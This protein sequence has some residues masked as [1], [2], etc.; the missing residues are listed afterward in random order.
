MSDSPIEHVVVLMME[1]HSY[2]HM[3]GY[4]P[5]PI[6]TLASTSQ[7][8]PNPDTSNPNPPLYCTTE[9]N[10]KWSIDP[11]PRH[12]HPDVMQQIYGWKYQQPP[13]PHWPDPAPMNGFLVNYYQLAQGILW[14]AG[15]W[16]THFVKPEFDFTCLGARV[17][18]I[19]VS[20]YTQP[21]VD[22]TVYEHA[23]ISATLNELFGIGALTRRDASAS[24]FLK[25][26]NPSARRQADSL[27]RP[28]LP[29]IKKP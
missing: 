29:I 18:A 4:F 10:D 8:L 14:N 13:P 7:C 1:N 19:I 15:T 28:L 2:D 12:S 3:L 20:A 9:W 21:G 6:G 24:S 16:G 26:V 27:P 5:P 17:P 22:A 11:C 25:N 23:S